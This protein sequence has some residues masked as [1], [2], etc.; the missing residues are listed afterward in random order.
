MSS[1]RNF[2]RVMN[3]IVKKFEA[4]TMKLMKITESSEEILVMCNV[5]FTNCKCER[6]EETVTLKK[7]VFLL[8]IG[9]HH[10]RRFLMVRLLLI[11]TQLKV[12]MCS[13]VS[14]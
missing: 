3:Q 12:F 10:I 2:K 9:D 13:T 5:S 11:E 6:S 7:E 1:V 14:C 4:S 8:G